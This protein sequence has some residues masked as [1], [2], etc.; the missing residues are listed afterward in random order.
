MWCICHFYSNPILCDYFTTFLWSFSNPCQS[1]LKVIQWFCEVLFGIVRY[2]EAQAF[3]RFCNGPALVAVCK[4][5]YVIYTCGFDQM[6]KWLGFAESMR[7]NKNK[8]KYNDLMGM[9]VIWLWTIEEVRPYCF[10]WFL[11]ILEWF[12]NDSKVILGDSLV[13]L[14]WF[15]ADSWMIHE[16]FSVTLN[17]S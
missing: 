11:V 15:S 4:D 5:S 6:G 3:V 10:M 12:S 16:Q 14:E 7:I 17:D 13:I 2:H 1:L 8:Y 9:C